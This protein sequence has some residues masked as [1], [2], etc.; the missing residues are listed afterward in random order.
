[1]RAVPVPLRCRTWLSPGLPLELFEAIVVALAPAGFAPELTAETTTS[2]P[3]PGPGDPFASGE[4]DLGFICAPSYRALAAADPSSVVLAGAAPVFDDER[5]GGRPVYFAELLVPSSSAAASLADLAGTRFGYNDLASQ[6][7]YRAL[8]DRLGELG[9][10]DAHF[11]EMVPTGGHRASLDAL[12]A[13]AI[14]A[15]TIDSNTLI[16]LGGAPDGTKV[17]ETWGP[18]PVQ[19]V[20]VASSL[21]ADVVARIRNQLLAIE[22]GALAPFNVRGFA[23]VSPADYA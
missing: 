20:V 15:A 12:R 9:L 22:P 19:P 1:V 3:P 16:G 8:L 18:F 13:G 11:A 23:P 6:S 5:N 2:G 7:G 14:D 10:D 17:I 21:D 4:V